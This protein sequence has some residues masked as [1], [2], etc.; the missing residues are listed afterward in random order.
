MSD[1]QGYNGSFIDEEGFL[2]SVRIYEERRKNKV[3]PKQECIEITPQPDDI[4]VLFFRNGVQLEGAVISW[5]NTV[6]VLKSPAGTATMV[7]QKTL[8]DIM[9]YKII[10]AKAHYEALVEK[11][12]KDVED[13]KKLA[14]LKCELNDLER[15]EIR[16][17]MKSHVPDAMRK[18][19][20]GIPG[21]NIKI[22][23]TIKHPRAQAPRTS[24]GLGSELQ[25]V[26]SKKH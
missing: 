15:A 20:Y 5:S 6:S 1:P 16:D 18:V 17:K 23:G 8:D 9:F 25:N 11:P 10:T 14:E 26:F 4:V 2:E 12:A 19:S 7:I 13:I 22:E 3:A 21:S 24:S